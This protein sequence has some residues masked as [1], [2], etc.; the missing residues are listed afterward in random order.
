MGPSGCHMCICSQQH[1]LSFSGWHSTRAT[2][3]DSAHL[4][5][6]GE[7]DDT[8]LGLEPNDLLLSAVSLAGKEVVPYFEVQ[9]GAPSKYA[10]RALFVG[11][12]KHPRTMEL[13][14]NAAPAFE[15]S[16]IVRGCLISPTNRAL[17]AYL[18]DACRQA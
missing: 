16:P 4:S 7:Q 10:S 17:D 12:I 1:A 2:Q 13:T 11:E 18:L 15:V 3:L 8:K 9:V 14:S 6:S 5:A